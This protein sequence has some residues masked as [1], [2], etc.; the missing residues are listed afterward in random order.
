MLENQK[1]YAYTRISTNK[2]TQKSDRQIDN[3]KSFLLANNINDLNVEFI[4]EI[5]SGKSDP[6]QRSKYSSLK[7]RL[8]PGDILIINDVDRLGRDAQSTIDEIRLLH[9]Q[10]IKLVILDTPYLNSLDTINDDI[11]NMIVD[12]LITLKS[13]IAHQERSKLSERVKQGLKA[14]NKKGG[15]PALTIEDI[16]KDFFKYYELFKK[17]KINK[18]DLSKL[19][20]LTRPTIDKYIKLLVNN[21]I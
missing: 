11:H 3:I 21:N 15:R 1:I 19:S 6:N 17:G 16:P 5:I 9:K 12:I 14:S 8:V 4:N 20:K 13:H 18:T 10:G 7:N 2:V